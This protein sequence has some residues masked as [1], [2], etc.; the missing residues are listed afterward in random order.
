MPIGIVPTT[1][2]QPVDNDW[3]NGLSGGHNLSYASGITAAGT[4]QATATQ[5]PDRVS[6]IEVDTTPSGTGV[7]LPSALKGMRIS[8]Y[9]NGANTLDVYP[10][11]ANNPVTGSQDTINNATSTTL[12]THVGA[13]YVGAKDGVWFAA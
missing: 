2:F 12:T 9:N 6:V 7:A 5:L 11:I 4:N 10:A 8:L 1:G 13:T 3:L